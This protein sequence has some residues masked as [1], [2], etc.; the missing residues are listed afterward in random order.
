MRAVIGVIVG[1]AAWTAVFLG[2]GALLAVLYPDERAAFDDGGD[3]RA[4]VPLLLSLVSSV[5]ASLAAGFSTAAIAGKRGA[6]L[7]MALLLLA[8]GI[9]VQ[10]SVWSRMPVW[11]HLV[12]LALLV[13][14]CLAAGRPRRS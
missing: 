4:T 7:V 13:P 11:Y 5:V 2:A 3:Y 6:V 9:G 14:V 12:F 8:T 10:A 1:Y